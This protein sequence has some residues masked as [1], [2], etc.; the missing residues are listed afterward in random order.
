M[1]NSIQVVTHPPYSPDLAPCDFFLFPTVKEKVKGTQFGTPD[2]A[3]TAF[4]SA[5]S[6]LS[7]EQWA[8]CFIVLENV[9]FRVKSRSNN[10][11]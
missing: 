11:I 3:V 5:V 2:V 1:Q 9:V 6:D 4:G 7:H 8:N 10:T